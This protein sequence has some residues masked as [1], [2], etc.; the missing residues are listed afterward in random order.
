M[1]K[2]GFIVIIYLYLIAEMIFN[3]F[4]F[5]DILFENGIHGGDA[6]WIHID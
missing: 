2:S 6:G 5:Y 1:K 4:S 3:Q